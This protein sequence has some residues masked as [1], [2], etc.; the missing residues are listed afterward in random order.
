MS[1]VVVTQP[2]LLLSPKER[3]KQRTSENGTKLKFKIFT[4]IQSAFAASQNKEFLSNSGQPNIE[5]G[6]FLYFSP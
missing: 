1:L 5:K 2:Q 3:L 6:K 4:L